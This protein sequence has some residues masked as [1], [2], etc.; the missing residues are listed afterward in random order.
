MSFLLNV[1]ILK[2]L[3]ILWEIQ[4][5]MQNMNFVLTSPIQPSKPGCWDETPSEVILFSITL[6]ICLQN[7]QRNEGIILRYMF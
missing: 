5:C 4:F 1:C 7:D 2:M 6:H 3:R